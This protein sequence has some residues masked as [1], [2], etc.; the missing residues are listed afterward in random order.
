MRLRQGDTVAVQF[1]L[2]NFDETT[3]GLIP[4]DISSV[5]GVFC[6]MWYQSCNEFGTIEEVKALEYA[7]CDVLEAT[8]GWVEVEATFP[9][10]GMYRVIY[11]VEDDTK[12]IQYP[13][14]ENWFI[15]AI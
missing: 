15:N 5:D 14:Y 11:T 2:M 6:D 10:L 3:S 12:T 9:S 1:Q 7:S 4:V 13:R 8:T